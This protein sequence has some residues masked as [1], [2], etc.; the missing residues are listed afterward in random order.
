MNV[1][2]P[3]P[4]CQGLALLCPFCDAG[5]VTPVP[6]PNTEVKPSR[7][8]GTARGT[9]WESRS[10][11][12]LIHGRLS[13]GDLRF[14]I[15]L[16]RRSMSADGGHRPP[17]QTG[18]VGAGLVPAL[19]LFVPLP[20][21]QAGMAQTPKPGCAAATQFFY[22]SGMSTDNR[23]WRRHWGRCLRHE[24]R[25]APC[26]PPTLERRVA[27]FATLRLLMLDNSCV[28][29]TGIRSVMDG[30]AAESQHQGL[31][32]T[33][34]LP[35][36]RSSPNGFCLAPAH[37]CFLADTA[38]NAIS[39]LLTARDFDRVPTYLDDE[40]LPPVIAW[41]YRRHAILRHVHTTHPGWAAFR[42]VAG[43]HLGVG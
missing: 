40:I 30:K 15:A 42:P 24:S 22:A 28:I 31:C 25:D 33:C 17:L 1:R 21:S 5:A 39:E 36:L 27:A 43:L 18:I 10:L 29:D 32:A 16:W 20:S 6:I 9:L 12:G 41:L 19:L 37:S 38:L 3:V 4:L 26:A 13:I 35:W 34:F 11:P 2:P 8:H 7:A 23:G 14:T